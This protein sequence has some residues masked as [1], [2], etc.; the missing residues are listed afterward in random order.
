[1]ELLKLVNVDF[2]VPDFIDTNIGS[3]NAN[4]SFL[5]VTNSQI[6]NS[7]NSFVETANSSIIG[8][9]GNFIA[10]SSSNVTLINCTNVTAVGVSNFVGVGLSNTIIDSSSSNTTS[11]AGFTGGGS[12]GTGEV[13]DMGNRLTGSD[14]TDMGNRI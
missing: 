13:I 3:G 9:S 12:S 6:N 7:P 11:I 14:S 10:N 5:Q 8:G 1:M 4:S 2:F